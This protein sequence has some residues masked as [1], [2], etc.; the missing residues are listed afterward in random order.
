MYSVFCD[1]CESYVF[2]VEVGV[3][4]K[5]SDVFYFDVRGGECECTDESFDANHWKIRRLS[6]E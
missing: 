5:D 1:R 4:V 3:I 2:N 6:D